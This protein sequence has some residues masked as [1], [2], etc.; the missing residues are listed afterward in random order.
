MPKN[1][2]NKLNFAQ[3]QRKNSEHSKG[4]AGAMVLSRVQQ[5]SHNA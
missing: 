2:V 4:N 5:L 1:S 3:R